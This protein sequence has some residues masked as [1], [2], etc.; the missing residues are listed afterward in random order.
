MIF[1]ALRELHTSR[2]ILRKLTLDDIPDYYCRLG[3][4]AAVTKYMLWQPHKDISESEASIQK[5]LCRYAERKCYR[6]GIALKEDNRII[7]VIELLRFNEETNTCS[8]AYMLAETYWGK[9]YGTEALTEV[10]RFA[11]EEMEIEAITAD[12]MAENPASGAVMQKCGMTYVRTIAS[13]YEKNGA[14]H[15]AVEYTITKE[16]WKIFQ[17]SL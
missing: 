12:H 7:G 16:R 4:S 2:L 6:F 15:D 9:G 11:F 3:S 14:W 8:F 13:K 10:F 1:P 17:G 5:A